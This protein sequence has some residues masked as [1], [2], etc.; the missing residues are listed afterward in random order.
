VTSRR[1][2]VR[3][4]ASSGN[5]GPGY[6]VLG[7]ALALFL[8]LEVRESP[9]GEFSI[10]PGGEGLPTDRE[11]LIVRSFERLHPADGIRFDVRNEIPLMR[12]LGSSAAAIVAGLLAADHLFELGNSREQIFAHA[13]EIEGHP[14][15]VAAALYGGVVVCAP[16][17]G[18]VRE[19]PPDPIEIAVGS[20]ATVPGERQVVPARLSPPEGVEGL[21]VIPEQEEVSTTAARQALPAKVPLDEAC[22]NAAAAIHLVLGIE[23][24][25]LTMLERGL[26]DRLHQQ[27]RRPLYERSMEIVEAAHDL[28]ALGATISGAG[29]TVLVWAYW[30]SSRELLT[31]LEHLAEG[32]AEVRRVTFS[33][34]GAEVE[35]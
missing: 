34:N 32:W 35:L 26:A 7:A 10:D 2:L 28:G 30:Q 1:R 6:D 9:D 17:G 24:S 27:Y 21:L 33:P 15:N 5:L 13:C 12:G 22:H 20:G 16:P 25:D 4:P 19:T 11:N 23:R 3:V 29:P 31:D 18:R 8:E 14:D